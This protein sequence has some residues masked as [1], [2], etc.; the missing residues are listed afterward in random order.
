MNIIKNSSVALTIGL[1]ELTSAARSMQ[2]YTFQVFEAFTAAT[3]IYIVITSSTCNRVMR[4]ARAARR[5]ARLHRPPSAKRRPLTCGDFDFD[6][7]ERSLGLPVP[8]GMTFTLTLTALAA[9]GGIIFGTLLA[10]MRLSSHQVAVAASPP[11][12]ST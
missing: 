8:E 9:I 2:E 10:L 4:C 3:L 1:V 12:T 5:S 7:I 6:V 11:A